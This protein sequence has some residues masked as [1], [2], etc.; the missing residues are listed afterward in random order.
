MHLVGHSF[1]AVIALSLAA[2]APDKVLSLTLAEP[3]F[4][5]AGALIDPS[6]IDQN[7]AAEAEL[8]AAFD[9]GDWE[10]GARL[11][12]RAWS[13]A[14]PKWDAMP[15]QLKDAMIRA[16]RVVP[17]CWPSISGD[18]QDLIAKLGTLTMPT[19]IIRGE[20]SPAA[21]KAITGAMAARMPN[22]REKVFE[23][24]GHMLPITHPK[25]TAAIVADAIAVA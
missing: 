21:M 25:E 12:N 23:T 22:A 11:F 20:H 15:Q 13:G 19:R 14:G 24:A 6:V 4:F 17:A 16:V 3:V 10:T 2:A 18:N 1:G 7:D 8:H 9:A 5:A